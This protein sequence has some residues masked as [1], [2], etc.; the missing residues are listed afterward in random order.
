MQ[1]P[2]QARPRAPAAP[3]CAASSSGF[4][5]RRAAA[6]E[7]DQQDALRPAQ[8]LEL[9]CEYGHVDRIEA[10]TPHWLR[11]TYASLR[12]ALGDDPVYIA[13]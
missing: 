6:A 4:L 9:A 13:E 3:Q 7:R 2:G 10:V 1:R 8:V 5:R 11:R 12:G